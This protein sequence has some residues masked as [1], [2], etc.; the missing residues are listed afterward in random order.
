MGVEIQKNIPIPND[1]IGIRGKFLPTYRKMEKGDSA[2]FPGF[3]T[4]GPA[5]CSFRFM[6]RESPE[7]KFTARRVTEEGVTGVRVWR[8]A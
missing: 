8:I 5:C 2:F 7:R 4:T 3:G 6:K 1:N